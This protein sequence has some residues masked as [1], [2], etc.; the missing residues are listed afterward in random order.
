MSSAAECWPFCLRANEIRYQNVYHRQKLGI[1][2]YIFVW[3]YTLNRGWGGG[4]YDDSTAPQVAVT[5]TRCHK[6]PHSRHTDSPP[7]SVNWSNGWEHISIRWGYK[8][9]TKRGKHGYFLSG[10]PDLWDRNKIL[11]GGDLS[12]LHVPDCI[13]EFSFILFDLC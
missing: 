6:R 2:I 10:V 8:S 11:R 3:V 1:Y 4:F 12:H 5:T 13:Y 7:R 9:D